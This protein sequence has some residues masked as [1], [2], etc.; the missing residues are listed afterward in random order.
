MNGEKVQQHTD[1]ASERVALETR[2]RQLDS[3]Y[4]HTFTLSFSHPLAASLIAYMFRSSFSLSV[5]LAWVGLV[6]IVG[7]IRLPIYQEYKRADITLEKL[8]C[9]RAW[10]VGIG[11]VQ[12]L[13]YGI[14]C[15][16][17]IELN[18]P[19]ASAIMTL[20]M[21]AL[22][23]I[24][25]VGYAADL[26][27]IFGFCLPLILPGVAG[28]LWLGDSISLALAVT[29]VFYVAVVFK[30][31]IPVNRTILESFAL[32][33][34]LHEQVKIREQAEQQLLT[35]SRQDGL[36]KLAN[37]RY[38]DET[39]NAE[40]NRARRDNG[41]LTLL[42]LDVDSF[43]PFNDTYG[44]VAGDECLIEVAQCLAKITKRS[45]DFVA[46]IGGEEFALILPN[47]NLQAA[48]QL[49]VIVLKEIR[50]LAIEHNTTIVDGAH[51]V[52]V[53]I[54][55]SVLT[56][57]DTVSGLVERADEHLYK[58]KSAGRDQAYI[59]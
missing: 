29:F 56:Q 49:A 35:L 2:R 31:M 45:G 28:L 13:L 33:E 34:Q 44:H 6:T 19:I 43:K 41:N 30:T 42:L 57:D 7:F 9:F 51:Y 5:L 15:L 4:R 12:G 14:A 54:G 58:A 48:Q 3:V 59:G 1:T 32:T 11:A 24:A 39:L 26:R 27:A 36:T 18:D 21:V 40:I 52:T 23:A 25:V 8:S 37:R 16:F 10:F 47:T 20:V 22:S 50:A 53:S 55:G 17:L 38:F 46:R